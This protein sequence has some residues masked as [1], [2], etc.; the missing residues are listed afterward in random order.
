MKKIPFGQFFAILL[1]SIIITDP[2]FA[3]PLTCCW[4]NDGTWQEFTSNNCTN[5][6]F[7]NNGW[8]GQSYERKNNTTCGDACTNL[9]S[10]C[11]SVGQ[12]LCNDQLWPMDDDMATCQQTFPFLCTPGTW[13][14]CKDA[15]SCDNWT[16]LTPTN[17][18]CTPDLITLVFFTA[19]PHD[20]YVLIDWATDMEIDNVG[21]HIWRSE[22]EDGE[23]IKITANLIPANG[24]G[25]QY[26][27]TD[28]AVVKGKNYYYK[29]EDID[30]YGASTFHGPILAGSHKG[31]LPAIQLLLGH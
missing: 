4:C 2:V 26:F 29:L 8:S 24:S 18:S 16:D 22:I 30:L 11:N 23:Y 27:F 31:F 20:S 13:Y 12:Q 3:G 5:T 10:T 28:N 21:F 19:T 9:N 7:S 1:C 14:E 17:C 25:Y 6:C 15:C